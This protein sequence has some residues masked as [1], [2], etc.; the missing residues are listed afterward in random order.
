MG[1][2]WGGVAARWR[3]WRASPRPVWWQGPKHYGYPVIVAVMAWV[4]FGQAVVGIVTG[5]ADPSGGRGLAAGVYASVALA[6]ALASSAL[7]YA[8]LRR[9]VEPREPYLA[10]PT[11]AERELRDSAER[12]RWGPRSPH[13]GV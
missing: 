2:F 3:G 8:H 12:L 13:D 5:G 1:R 10:S 9:P 4:A 11:V 6:I 7:I